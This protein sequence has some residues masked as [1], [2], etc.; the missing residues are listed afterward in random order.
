VLREHC[1]AAGVA[2]NPLEERDGGRR[3]YVEDPF[4]NRIERIKGLTTAG[5][6]AK[7]GQPKIRRAGTPRADT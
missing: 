3:A 1:R 4:G 7:R 2:L 6:T 5:A